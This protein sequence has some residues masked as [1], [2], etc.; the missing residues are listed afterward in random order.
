M[1]GQPIGVIGAGA[2]GT[3]LASVMS[4]NHDNVLLW[5]L[6]PEVV[7]AVNA[8]KGNP[9]YLPGLALPPQIRATAEMAEMADCSALLMVTPAQHLRGTLERLPETG[10]PLLLCSRLV[11]AALTMAFLTAL[12]SSFAAPETI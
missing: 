10:A 1:T 4:Q 11:F 6:E 9:L 7:E 3:A 5:A 8:G 2:W 12:T